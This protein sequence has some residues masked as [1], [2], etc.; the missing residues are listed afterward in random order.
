MKTLK[1]LL[2][3]FLICVIAGIGG[4]IG[5]Y[6]W[7]SKDL[8]GFKNITDYNPPLVTTVYAKDNQ[9]LGYFYKEKRFL[10][11]LDQM[12]PWLPKA[13]LA[14]E[15]ASFYEHD[16]IDLT[17]I[18]RAFIA[19]MKAG[20]TKQ[21]GST[22]T[23]QII[24]RLLL[25]SEKSYKRK[26][27]EA[28]LAFRLE[29]YLTKEEI[30]TIYL[31]QIF[32]GA[33][34]YG[35]E[36]AARTY[37]AK[38]AKDLTIAECAMLAG[39]PQA[40]SRYNPYRNWELAKQRQRYVLQQ[41]HNLG[42][43]TTPQYREAM[44]ERVEL[45]SMEDPSWK[46]GAY[47]LEEVRRWLINQYGEETV[48]N[49]GL[50]VTTACDIKH[51]VSAEKALRRGLLNSAKR[52]GWL[53]PIE[54]VIPGDSARILAEG[55][56]TVEEFTEKDTPMKA[57][58]TKVVKE[59]AMVRFGQFEGVIPIK[60]MWWVREPN[61]KKSH[62]D[63]PDPTDARK[64]LKKGDVILVTI[65]KNPERPGDPYTLDM[66]REP[67][68]EGAVFSVKPDTGE[69]P[70]LVGGYSFNK[71][72]FNRATQAKRQ[73]GSAFK[74]IVYSTAIDNGFTP[75]SILLDAPIVYANDEQ[76]KLWRPE[77]FEGTFDGPTL[78]RTALVKSKNLVTIRIAQK[79]GIRKIINRAKDM[80]LQTEFPEDLSVA[81]GSAV[82]TLE[83]LC[84]AYTA[85]ARGGSYIK[86][87]TV[88]SVTSAWGD[89]MYT[90]VPETV[91]A[92]SPQTA[93]IMAT[94]MKH[95]VQYG[96]GWRARK[97]G[98]PLA[99]KTGT[100]NNEQDAWYMGYSPYLLTGVF[101]GFDEL[102]PMG[103]WE[104]G[105]RAASSIWVDYRKDVEEDYPYQDFTQPPGIVMVRVDGTS[106]KLASPS[107]TK[108][109]FLP[110]KVGT[111]PTEM[112]R[113]GSSGGDA[114]ASADDLFKQTF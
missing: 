93:Y 110:F 79:L 49:G 103:K 98:R 5:L 51:Q 34:S 36:A 74:P 105:S 2:I 113:S 46:V 97:L 59:K 87:R 12:S 23:Q 22:I 29:N 7:A 101:V 37:F 96:T 104:T 63:V 55:P 41:L 86:P 54:N 81:L 80:G 83:N 64:I 40:P 48:Y 68:V 20:R 99:G 60:N 52:R 11:T 14:A 65:D 102:K 71:S 58:V 75:A 6:N 31:N 32:L 13:F 67:L 24:K 15:D 77:N 8:P 28:I 57:W 42:W 78:L 62:E 72:Q 69:V 25:T 84:E 26:L 108:E 50:T 10:V 19:N 27:K 66:E 70:A 111:E 53:G 107:S 9:V 94:L 91:D 114:P 90:S 112:S 89:E 38:H 82:V 109:F 16:G 39:L 21:G 43:I 45:K 1:I 88:L 47:Y 95:V 44:A 85:F 17:A 92:I 18:S 30:L 33:H 100:S 73:P 56:Q 3:I 35:V 61:I 4:A 76:G 106:G